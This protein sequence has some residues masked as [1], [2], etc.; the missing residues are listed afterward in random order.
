MTYLLKLTNDENGSISMEGMGKE[1]INYDS[2]RM[3]RVCCPR[4]DEVVH[5]H[6]GFTSV[7][8]KASAALLFTQ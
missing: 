6:L 5:T 3:L 7:W 8:V 2:L 4:Q 1:F